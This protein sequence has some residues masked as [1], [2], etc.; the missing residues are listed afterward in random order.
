MSGEQQPNL[1]AEIVIDLRG[2]GVDQCFH[3]R[4]P[5]ALAARIRPGQRVVVPFGRRTQQGFVMAVLENH[6]ADDAAL[7]GR[8]RDVAYLADDEPL[9]TEELID[10]CRWLRWR[11]VCSWIEAIHA[12]LPAAYRTRT[13][14][15]IAAVEPQDSRESGQPSALLNPFTAEVWAFIQQQPRRPEVLEKRFGPEVWLALRQ[16]QALGYVRADV[17]RIDKARARTVAC[18]EPRKPAP[19]LVALAEQRHRRA[20]RQAELLFTLAA[21]GRVVLAD[22]GLRPA[23]KPVRA[24]VEEGA[25]RLVHE[26][27]GRRVELSA[28]LCE[29]PEAPPLTDAQQRALAKIEAALSGMLPTQELLLHGVTGSGK[30]EVFL[31]AIESVRNQGGGAIVLVP[32]IGLTPQ[33]VGRFVARFGQQVAV[34]HSGLSTGERRD[35]WVRIRRGQARIVVGARSAIFAPVEDLRL[36]VVDEEH[37]P[38]YKQEDAPHYDAREVARMRAG[39]PGRVVVLASATPSLSAMHRAETGAALIMTLPRRVGNRPMPKVEIVDM[40]QEF[41]DGNHSLF[42]RALADGLT[43]AVASGQQAIL[44]LNRRGFAQFVQCRNCGDSL[45]CPHCDITLTLHRSEAG[46][47]MRCHYCGYQSH[48]PTACPR[49]GERA[50]RSFGI[51]TQQ[52]ETAVRERWP[53]LRVLRMDVDTTRRKGAHQDAIE[54]FVSGQA[55][56][57]IGTQMVAKGL[58][59]PGV[60]FVGVLAADTLLAVP[61]YRA[62]ERTFDL[63]AQVAGRAGRGET[64]GRT[65]IQTF[66]P[67][68]FAIQAAARHDYGSF[69]RQEKPAREQFFYPPFSELAVLLASHPEERLARSAAARFERELRRRLTPDCATVL[70]AHPAGIA[71]LED[72]YRYQVV[73]KYTRWQDV[74]ES[75]AD[76]FRLVREKMRRVGGVCVLDVDAGRIA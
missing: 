52:V 17:E 8:L 23:D 49:C 50:L 67:E 70:P 68:H 35:E 13:V 66:R 10:I 20:K 4:V 56:V 72:Q 5:P 39:Q 27:V 34:L 42:S 61:D 22:V 28:R 63:L 57:L 43:N 59:F 21:N 75:V 51:G 33:M 53:N 54:Q 26:E 47:Q 60:T 24:L 11:Y 31:Q 73:V 37:E 2:K 71:R 14:E 41:K 32:E 44:F 29:N 64:P 16:L 18:L 7:S 46:W 19:E 69:Y 45:E 58:D 15:R 9:L 12:V 76:A 38:S 36:I 40:R 62:S 65:V 3:Y 25:V 55:D 74:A 6:P 48:L 1:V 30:T